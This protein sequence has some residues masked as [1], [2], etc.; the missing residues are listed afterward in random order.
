MNDEWGHVF[1]K[2]VLVGKGKI[3]KGEGKGGHRGSKRK[4]RHKVGM[5]S[6]REKQR[7]PG[8]VSCDGRGRALDKLARGSPLPPGHVNMSLVPTTGS[9]SPAGCQEGSRLYQPSRPPDNQG[10]P[11]HLELQCRPVLNWPL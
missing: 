9:R 10:S 2:S 1:K 6:R 4:E 11:L 7:V 8:G 3:G 5:E